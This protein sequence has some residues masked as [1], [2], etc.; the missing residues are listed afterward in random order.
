MSQPKF[1]HPDLCFNHRERQEM[2][3]RGQ[4]MTAT[5]DF[6]RAYTVRALIKCTACSECV[7]A[8]ALLAASWGESLA[9]IVD[10]QDILQKG[11]G[12]FMEDWIRAVDVWLPLLGI[13]VS[14]CV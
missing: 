7:E 13:K 14:Y 6:G 3:F 9:S 1:L 4:H 2:I 12:W 11:R 8:E 10:M 5:Q